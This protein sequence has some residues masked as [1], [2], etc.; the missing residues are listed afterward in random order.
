MA[1]I[2][3]L[4]SAVHILYARIFEPGFSGL[5]VIAR[6]KNRGHHG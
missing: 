6:I 5:S 4:H 2:S 3:S 1:I